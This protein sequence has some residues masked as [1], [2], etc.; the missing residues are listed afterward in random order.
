MQSLPLRVCRLS[1]FITATGLP[2]LIIHGESDRLVPASNSLRLAA[3]L[4]G[5]ELALIKEC[6]H[7]PQEECPR[8]FTELVA[9][10]VDRRVVPRS[11]S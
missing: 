6:G 4:P 5:C 11:G 1:S 10:F 2:V 7:M 8:L 3:L 9:D